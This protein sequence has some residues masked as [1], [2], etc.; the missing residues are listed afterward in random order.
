MHIQ[1]NWLFLFIGLVVGLVLSVG[2]YFLLPTRQTNTVPLNLPAEVVTT[3]A[4]NPT[5]QA[6]VASIVPP[7]QVTEQ[8]SHPQA[9]SEPIRSYQY[10]AQGRLAAI[11]YDDGSVYAYQ[12]DAYGNKVREIGRTGQTWSYVY[13]PSHHPIAIVDPEGRVT[14][15]ETSSSTSNAN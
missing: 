3:P 14:H 11:I 9:S 7:A 13:D 1:R 6:P 12:Y 10:T 5:S 15:K 8:A 2:I 4:T